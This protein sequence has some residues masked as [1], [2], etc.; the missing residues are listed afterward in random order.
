MKKK[1]KAILDNLTHDDNWAAR[2]SLVD[3]QSAIRNLAFTL[4]SHSTTIRGLA[5]H[6]GRATTELEWILF[7]LAK[8]FPKEAEKAG[9]ELPRNP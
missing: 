3:T 8:R 2:Y 9:I 7:A 1:E 6:V 4:S 5:A